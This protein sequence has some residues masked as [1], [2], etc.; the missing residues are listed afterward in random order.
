MKYLLPQ[1]LQNQMCHQIVS[2]INSL[3]W[4]YDVN[5]GLSSRSHIVGSCGYNWR[6]M[7]RSSDWTRSHL[8]GR[9]G[10]LFYDSPSFYNVLTLVTL[11]QCLGRIRKLCSSWLKN[12]DDTLYCMSAQFYQEWI[13]ALMKLFQGA[14]SKTCPDSWS[15]CYH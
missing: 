6:F 1:C 2:L 13:Q 9:E 4:F 15:V 12:P 3:S 7:S 11:S 14:S 8:W 5:I 10:D